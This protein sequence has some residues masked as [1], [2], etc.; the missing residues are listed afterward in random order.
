[1]T[2]DEAIETK[3]KHILVYYQMPNRE[4]IY[5]YIIDVG[6]CIR[7]YDKKRIAFAVIQDAKT[8]KALYHVRP[9]YIFCNDK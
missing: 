2:L 4:K 8:D 6:V 9:R 5:G 1:M 7:Q 3:D